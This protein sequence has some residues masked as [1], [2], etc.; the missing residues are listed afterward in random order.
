MFRQRENPAWC[1]KRVDSDPFL[2]R[3]PVGKFGQAEEDGVTLEGVSVLCA[4][5]GYPGGWVGTWSHQPDATVGFLRARSPCALTPMSSDPAAWE[6]VHVY[7]GQECPK[8]EAAWGR[9]AGHDDSE[10]PAFCV[11]MAVQV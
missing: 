10:S 4:P 5:H 11:D 1:F 9:G 7:R 8:V 6:A 2:L 3:I